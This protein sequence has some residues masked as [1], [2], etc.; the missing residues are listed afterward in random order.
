MALLMWCQYEISF[1][2][3]EHP[4]SH[5]PSTVVRDVDLF[6]Y[7]STGWGI[8]PAFSKDLKH[9]ETKMPPIFKKENI[10]LGLIAL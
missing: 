5:D 8:T 4:Y 7:F 9:W 2:Q 3:T 1:A 6:W 10:L